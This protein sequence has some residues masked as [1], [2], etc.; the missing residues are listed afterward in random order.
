M[1]FIGHLM[2]SN[3]MVFYTIDNVYTYHFIR[4]DWQCNG[5]VVE[6]QLADKL[7]ELKDS[8]FKAR[9]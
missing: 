6:D 7:N 9:L 3:R 5:E 8:Y 2:L 1:K 4:K